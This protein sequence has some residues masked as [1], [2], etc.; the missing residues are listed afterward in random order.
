MSEVTSNNNVSLILSAS[1]WGVF[2]AAFLVMLKVAIFVITGSTSIKISL[3]DSCFDVL[4]SSV[5]H[6]VTVLSFRKCK[7]YPYGYDKVTGII[8]V[9]QVVILMLFSYHTAMGAWHSIYSDRVDCYSQSIKGVSMH[10]A[11]Q[12]S[13]GHNTQDRLAD[14][15]N[16]LYSSCSDSYRYDSNLLNATDEIRLDDDSH[17]AMCVSRMSISHYILVTIL[18]LVSLVVTIVLVRYQSY[19]I[20]KTGHLIVCT[21]RAHYTTDILTNLGL[22]V[23][24]VFA[25]FT[26]ATQHAQIQFFD[27]VLTIALFA[28]VLAC[29]TKVLWSTWGVMMDRRLPVDRELHMHSVVMG[30]DTRIHRAEVIKSRFSGIK[31][32]FEVR[33]GFSSQISITDARA[34]ITRLEKDLSSQGIKCVFLLSSCT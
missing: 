10:D 3:L 24:F 29:C 1:L 16:E 6:C 21:D 28:Y 27:S 2:V 33:L 18:L 20:N 19:V 17:L 31:E 32:H 8:A 13:E 12:S 26:D 5:N 23:F 11:S 7:N 15:K 9:V 30:M 34:I 14:V 4:M 22:L 25:I